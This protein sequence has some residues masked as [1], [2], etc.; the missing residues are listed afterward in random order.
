[1]KRMLLVIWLGLP[2][3]CGGCA[4][5]QQGTIV[6]VQTTGFSPYRSEIIIYNNAGPSVTVQ[7]FSRG[8]GFVEEYQI[9]KRKWYYLWL[10]RERIPNKFFVVTHGGSL[11]IPMRMN[12]TG[13][14]M[15]Q[16]IGLLIKQNN[17][18]IGTWTQCVYVPNQT[19][20]TRD[21][22]FGKRELCQ[23]KNGQ[24]GYSCGGYSGGAYW[25]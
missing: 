13:R 24:S 3:I 25:W 16:S 6:R 18:I 1:M 19:A 21:I 5:L 10:G 15:E 12:L 22:V 9:G 4:T 8:K 23:L 17:E 20:V 7:P 11:R 2:L 14:T